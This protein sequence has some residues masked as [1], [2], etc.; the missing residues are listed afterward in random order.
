MSETDT[1]LLPEMVELWQQTL[2]WQ[3][4]TE[5]Q[6]QFQRLYELIVEGNRHLNL[7]R[8]TEPMEFWEKHLWDSLR[9]IAP[10]LGAR[11]EKQ[12]AVFKVID[13]GT[14]A[15]FPG[16]PVAITLP[17][18]T[19]TLLDSTRK[20]ITFLNTLLTE[21]GIQNANTVIGRAETLGKQLQ[22]RQSYDIALIR[23]VGSATVCAEYALP[24]LKLGGLAV[25]YRGNWTTAETEALQSTVERLGSVIE[26][27][28]AFTTPLSQ[29]IRHCLYLR[30]VAVTASEFPRPV[31]MAN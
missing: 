30:K 24:F 31:R 11:G 12:E 5:Q 7:T 20:K 23:A 19:V 2:S 16:I 4:T 18:A 6:D 8:I 14:G 25:L 3:P 13:I 22:Y 21:L 29:G 1:P 9:G 17:S 15:G 10:L 26:A 27:T 28:E